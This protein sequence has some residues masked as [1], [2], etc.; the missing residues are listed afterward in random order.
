[1]LMNPSQPAPRFVV[2][3]A[4]DDGPLAQEVV[5]VGANFARMVPGG[6]LHLIHVLENLPPP[7]SLVPPPTGMGL[8]AAEMEAEARKRLDELLALARGKFAGRIVGHLAAGSASREI[9]QVAM[10]L[11][12]DAVVVGTHGRTGVKRFL[13]G[14]V[15]E[16]VVRKA[17]CPVIVVRPKD[18]Q[19]VVPPEIEPPCPECQLVQQQTAGTRLWCQRHSAQHPRAHVHYEL[20][21]GFGAGSQLIRP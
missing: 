21:E 5:R 13:V 18:Y 1:M 3:G 17:S 9:I 15:A 2:I 16:S 8:T 11:Q 19:G 10:D 4:V 14:S 7:V 12:A 6:E 20:P